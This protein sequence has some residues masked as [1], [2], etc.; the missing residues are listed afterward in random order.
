VII[1]GGTRCRLRSSTALEGANSRAVGGEAMD[2]RRVL[3]VGGG[4]A[5]L[6]LAPMLARIGVAVE[7]IERTPV[8]RPAGTGIYLPGNAARALRALGLEGQV[9]SRAVEIARQRFYDHH[10][11]LLCEVDVAELWAGVGPCLALHRAELH[12]LLREAAGDVP[13]RIGLALERLAQRDGIVSVEL[14][15]GTSG[16]YDLVIGADGI[17]SA[18][19]RLTF[20]PTAVPRPVGQVGWRFLAPRPPEVTTWSVMLGRGTAF[21][22][23]PVDD[24]RVY[25]YCDVVSPRD[26]D[27]PERAPAE[28]PSELFSEFVDPAATLL[29]GLDTGAET[30]VSTIEEV[31]LEC[32]AHERVVLIGDA[33]HATSPNMAQGA[34]MALEDAL[35]LTDCLHRIP[36]IP[37][38]VAVFQA[39]RRPRTDWVRV[40]T[41]RRDHTRHLPPPIRDNVLRFLGRRIFHAN[42][43]PLLDQP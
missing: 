33:A 19:R 30:Q 43:R 37:D 36:A 12:A 23:L 25:C 9:A 11:R 38:A 1:G 32:W 29:D 18:V 31:A 4:I 26:H 8:L 14:S 34:A 5:G 3:I 21:L 2:R 17:Q 13:I 16:E 40:Q 28:P 6:A 22:T 15:D 7:V 42:Y 10:G 39:R 20:E 35:V 24:E 41:Y 27:T